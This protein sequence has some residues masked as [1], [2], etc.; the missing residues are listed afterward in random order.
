[1]RIQKLLMYVLLNQIYEG[2]EKSCHRDQQ[3]S[4]YTGTQQ[5]TRI[6]KY[7]FRRTRSVQDMI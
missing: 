4:L 5:P 2:N 3:V 7:E 1:M 6:F